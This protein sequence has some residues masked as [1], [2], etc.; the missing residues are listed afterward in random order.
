M[1][2]VAQGNGPRNTDLEPIVRQALPG[3]H[4]SYIAI[5]DYLTVIGFAHEVRGNDLIVQVIWK[6]KPAHDHNPANDFVTSYV[7]LTDA[8]GNRIQGRDVRF[9]EDFS[10]LPAGGV[11]KVLTYEFHLSG[12]CG[13]EARGPYGLRV[14]AYYFEDAAATNLIELVAVDLSDRIVQ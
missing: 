14:G 13:L 5:T 1:Q 6:L 12:Q 11:K 2:K 7:H 4:A 9:D 10:T 3:V 8:K